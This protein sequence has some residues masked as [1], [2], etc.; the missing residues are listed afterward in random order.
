MYQLRSLEND[1]VKDLFNR[2]RRYP[3]L[4]AEQEQ[5]YARQIQA[6]LPTRDA[7]Q[8]L[9]EELKRPPTLAEVA[10]KLGKSEHEIRDI[11]ITGS[12]AR[13]KMINHNLRLVVSIAKKYT[14]REIH[15]LDLFQDG[16]TG[17]N[18]A[19]E[20]FDPDMGH[21]FS[22]YA[23]WWIR[24]AIIRSIANT[25]R[26]IRLPVH[27]NEK[28]GKLNRYR[29]EFRKQY[30]RE[31]ANFDELSES[32]GVPADKLRELAGYKAIVNVGSLN[33]TIG[34][35]DEAEI[36]DLIPSYQESPEDYVDGILD[37]EYAQALMECL[38][39][40]EYE[41]VSLRY[42]MDDCRAM[43]LQ[44]AADHM[45]L[46]KE[47]VRQLQ[48]NAIDKMRKHVRRSACIK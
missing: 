22:T 38:T 7:R 31:P 29:R 34:K 36:G 19:V 12:R 10:E 39:P 24:Q 11:E 13:E 4:N 33:K 35:S 9:A 2:M 25:G 14:T 8:A 28:V 16:C 17:L 32:C 18:T 30:G 40:R 44:Q 20:R 42:G 5:F 26:I 23:T 1:P 3:L 48:R 27:M 21:K 47:R 45:G 46:S 15:L 43:T 6:F 41:A 37:W